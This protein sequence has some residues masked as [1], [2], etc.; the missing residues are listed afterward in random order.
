[1][2]KTELLKEFSAGRNTEIVK[3]IHASLTDVNGRCTVIVCT[4]AT[5]RTDIFMP[6]PVLMLLS[7]QLSYLFIIN[8][9]ESSLFI[10]FIWGRDNLSFDESF[11]D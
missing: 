6:V 2:E 7:E 3:F 8:I 11:Y 10:N 1:M 5:L 9:R 4:K